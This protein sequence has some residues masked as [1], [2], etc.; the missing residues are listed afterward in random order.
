MCRKPAIH[1]FKSSCEDD[2]ARCEAALCSGVAIF[3]PSTVR[4]RTPNM[5]VMMWVCFPFLA[6]SHIADIVKASRHCVIHVYKNKNDRNLKNHYLRRGESEYNLDE[7]TS[8]Y[9]SLTGWT[10]FMSLSS[11]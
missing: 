1:V 4:L 7:T 3:L 8:H 5:F 11:E 6:K 2:V 9:C 10:S